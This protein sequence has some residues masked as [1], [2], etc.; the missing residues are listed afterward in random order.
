MFPTLPFEQPIQFA[1][2]RPRCAESSPTNGSW[3]NELYSIHE[4]GGIGFSKGMQV[5]YFFGLL[6]RPKTL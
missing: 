4:K 6:D 1:Y 5:S 3:F 2:I